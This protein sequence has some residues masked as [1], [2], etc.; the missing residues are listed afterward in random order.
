[1][2]MGMVSPN[3]ILD[4]SSLLFSL[5]V[6][7]LA[8]NELSIG[9]KTLGSLLFSREMISLGLQGSFYKKVHIPLSSGKNFKDSRLLGRGGR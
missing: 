6:A 2:F 1:M 5:L 4:S 7:S 3:F 9:V 8:E